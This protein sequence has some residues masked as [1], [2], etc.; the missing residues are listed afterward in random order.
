MDYSLQ[1]F[2]QEA[3]KAP[4]FKNTIFVLWGDHGIPR[5]STDTRFGDLTLA[6]HQVPLLIYAPGMIEP[7]RDATVASQMDILPT[8][9]SLLGRSVETQTLGKDLL[10]PAFRDRAAAFTFTTFRRPPRTGLIQG[11][12]YLNLEPDG[13]PSLFRLD[14]PVSKGHS[15]PV[16]RSKE[17]SERTRNMKALAQAFHEWSKFL[18]SHNP[19]IEEQR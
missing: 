10:D 14:D 4:Y 5:G 3:E 6:I 7:R 11:N 18:L 17:D 16:E 13:R 2:F 9:M 19:P 12:H 8:L 1:K 15:D